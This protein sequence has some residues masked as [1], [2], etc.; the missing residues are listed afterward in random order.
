M[1]PSIAYSYILLFF[2]TNV[3]S[4]QFDYC[5]CVSPDST[6][7]IGV[8]LLYYKCNNA[9][10]PSDRISYSITEPENIINVLDPTKQTNIFIFGW[11]L[12]PD[13]ILVQYMMEA[14][15]NGKTTNVVLLDWSKYS[16]GFYLTVFNNAQGVGVLFAQCLQKLV[17]SGLDVSTIYI[18]GFSLGAHIAGIAGKCNK[19]FQLI[20]ITGLDPA[21]RYIPAVSNNTI[22]KGCYL[23]PDAAKCVDV[24][25]TDMGFYGT[26]ALPYTGTVEF[27]ANGGCR[28]QPNCTSPIP[29]SLNISEYEKQDLCS[30]RRV[31]FLFITSIYN[32]T[33]IMACKF[34][35]YIL[36]KECNATPIGYALKDACNVT[37][38]YYF[39]AGVEP[40]YY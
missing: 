26:P 20:R 3:A 16:S 4:G 25:H 28:Y 21:N 10:D 13:H 12:Y 29:A 39:N 19:N 33:K 38:N 7:A 36:N 37:G 14:L 17:N 24:I 1:L 18:I 22:L 8:N 5:P 6:F 32:S 30:H 2:M 15:C 23:T 35:D 9:T 31:M 11:Q 27:F 34:N 40:Y